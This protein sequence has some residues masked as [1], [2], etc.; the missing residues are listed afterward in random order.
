MVHTPV[1][2]QEAMKIP[3]A[4]AAIDKEWDKLEQRQAWVLKG[5]REKSE[6]A[7]EAKKT[8]ST[9][10]FGNLMALCH[11]KHSELPKHLQ[12]Y[13]G[14]VVFRGDDVRD[15]SGYLAVF[16]SKGHQLLIWLL[17]KCLMLYLVLKTW[18]VRKRML[19]GP[20]PKLY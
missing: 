11:I 3:D 9:G 13:K 10:H 6:V 4:R 12:K 8:G 17:L 20:I 19:L 16:L 7:A 5:V 15:E 2:I 18:T 1:P 14:R